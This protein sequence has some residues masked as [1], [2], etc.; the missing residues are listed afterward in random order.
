MP[1]K[2]R[3]KVVVNGDLRTCTR[4]GLAFPTAEFPRQGGRPKSHCRACNCALTKE[5]RLNNVE[6]NRA[7]KATWTEQNRELVKASAKAWHTRNADK[8]R[9][10]NRARTRA[11]QDSHRETARAMCREWR[12]NN[13]ERAMAQ[14]KRWRK[15]HLPRVLAHNARRRAAE[16]RATPVW[17]DQAS[18][19]AVYELAALLTKLTGIRHHVDHIVPLKSKIVCGLHVA[20]NLQAIPGRDNMSK[21]DRTWPDMPETPANETIRQWMKSPP[22]ARLSGPQEIGSGLPFTT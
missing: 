7:R 15:E 12:A 20:E 6:Q 5:W 13:L 14:Q 4:C 22:D 18:I 11:W 17:A 2:I 8:N 21:G 16:V 9:E 3:T 19:T 1:R 10:R